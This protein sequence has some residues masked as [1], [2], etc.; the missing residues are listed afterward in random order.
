MSRKRPLIFVTNDDSIHAKGIRHLIEVARE[1]GDVVVVA[2]EKPQSGMSHALT[3]ST[4][5]RL[6]KLKEEKGFLEYSCNGTPVDCL[7]LALYVILKKHPDVILSG[8]NH[9]S[10]ASV[11]VIYSGTMAVATEGAMQGIPSV[12][13]S[14]CSYEADADFTPCLPHVRE[15]SQA[16]LKN[17][18]PRGVCL[19]VN[20][21]AVPA[22]KIKGVKVVRQ[23]RGNWKEEFIE[24]FD[25]HGRPYY[26]LT[27]EFE[28]LD[29][30]KDTD[31]FALAANYVSVVP[32][33]IDFTAY[34]QIETV[35]KW[36]L[37]GKKK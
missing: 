20:V 27:G 33:G 6:R 3:V 8:I 36:N 22:S 2:P 25:P 13:F 32:T 11:N 7:K 21:P 35:K 28:D 10:N 24:R 34:D 29:D 19:N 15:I 9:G 26:W 31:E 14:L 1:M 12:G 37:K 30:R 23:A 4:F 17:G 5:L 16:V 18:L